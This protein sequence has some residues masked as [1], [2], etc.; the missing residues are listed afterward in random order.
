MNFIEQINP[1]MLAN[2]P[3]AAKSLGAIRPI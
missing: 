1:E 2:F 3:E